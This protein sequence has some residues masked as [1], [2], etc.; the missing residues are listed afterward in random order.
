MATDALRTDVRPL[1]RELTRSERAETSLFAEVE[2]LLRS[3]ASLKLTVALLGMAAFL[4][5]VGTLAQTSAD[6]LAVVNSYFRNWLVWIPF[7]V[8]FPRVFFPEMAPVGGGFWFPGGFTIGTLMGLN[9][10]TAHG[11]RF[12]IQARGTRLAAG[13]GVIAAGVLLTALVIGSQQETD[14]LT[15]LSAGN[16]STVWIG[17][18]LT[19]AAAWAGCA[20]RLFNAPAERKLERR[21]LTFVGLLVGALLCW[22]VYRWAI[23]A[24]RP[25][26]DSSMRILWQLIKAESAALV[27]LGGCVLLFKKRAGVVLLHAGILLMMGNELVVYGTHLETV[28][29][30]HEGEKKDWVQDIRSFELVIADKSDRSKD[31]SVAIPHSRLG[32]GDAVRD[33]RLPFDVEVVQFIANSELSEIPAKEKDQNLATRGLGLDYRAVE[34]PAGTG[35]SS[36][37]AVD[38][39][40]AYVRLLDKKT[41]ESLGT[42][43]TTSLVEHVGP[44]T[45]APQRFEHEGKVYE[46]A[47]RFPRY[48]K[49]YSVELIDVRKDD[50]PGTDTPR[51]YSSDIRLVHPER[52][53]DRQVRTWMNNPYRH[54]GDTF[55]Q[56]NYIRDPNTGQEVSTLSV[57]SNTG[58][59][60]PYVGCMIVATGMLAHF[61]LTLVRFIQRRTVA[62]PVATLVDEPARRFSAEPAVSARKKHMDHGKAS[63]RSLPPVGSDTAISTGTPWLSR[64]LPLIVLVIFGGYALSKMRTPSASSEKMDLYAFGQLPLMYQGRVKP[65]DSLARQALCVI[66][67]RQTVEVEDE[68]RRTW[69]MKLTHRWPKEPA[70]KWLLDT[71]ARPDVADDYKVFRIENPEVMTQLGIEPREGL[72]YSYNELEKNL[73]EFQKQVNKASEL[74]EAHRGV[75]ENKLL[76]TARR[77]RMYRLV[78]DSFTPLPIEELMQEV[79]AGKESNAEKF[80]KMQRLFANLGAL[81]T[82]LMKMQPPLAV[83]APDAELGWLPYTSAKTHEFVKQAIRGQTPNESVAHLEKIFQAYAGGDASK[84]SRAVADYRSYLE[85]NA[86]DDLKAAS[87]RFEAFFNNAE[88]FYYS[89]VLYLVAFVLCAISWLG[90]AGPLNRAAFW[91]IAFTFLYH[92]LALAARIYISG[93][94]PVTNLYSS[95]VFIGWGCVLL[96]L[97]YEL[98]F[99]K[100]EGKAVAGVAGI[101][102]VGNVMASIAGFGTLVIAH[103]LLTETSVTSKELGDTMAVMQAVL[104]TQFWLATHVVCITLGYATTFVAGLLG[105]IYVVRG[106]LSRSLSADA[107]KE[108]AR[109]IY[110]TLCFAIFFSL[111]GTILGGLWADDSW[112]RFWGWDVKENGALIIVLW[113]ALVLHARWDGMAKDRGLAVLAIGGN[114]VTAWSWFGVNEL[115]VGLHSYG[116]TEGA[117]FLLGTFVGVQLLLIAA[118][119]LPKRW[120]L[121]HRPLQQTV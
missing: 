34:I 19:L 56:T 87:P 30:L 67:N 112:G 62:V 97:V 111:V 10:L 42:W 110:G 26:G 116:F 99:R 68:S 53:V 92:T 14:S 13:L 21:A 117:L 61:L 35:V 37:Q 93:R 24:E 100:R 11:L 71:I 82:E 90:F 79:A 66:S 31:E 106:L 89:A 55:Y 50:Y 109:M 104:D 60:I 25:L 70:I 51:N 84:V 91:L 77:I 4:V 115:R 2:R 102:G 38:V 9:L 6:I 88:P 47:L 40:S 120:W 54:A 73:G 108:L 58:W 83:P 16:W 41:G 86:P 81:Q 52:G 12:R 18:K 65:M 22:L 98:I 107:G 59:M 64:Y 5:F 63:R 105:V 80:A 28:M 23:G 33:D 32:T 20:Y 39:A 96:G 78:R 17:I 94:P 7:Q 75:F 44:E 8:F 85:K 119:S 118:G 121:S 69:W 95:A 1:S 45:I 48:N 46:I 49:P 27:L 76:E 3:L 74:P 43:L 113:N 101:T 36:D 72:R 114:I 15:S 103:L 57:V 29:T